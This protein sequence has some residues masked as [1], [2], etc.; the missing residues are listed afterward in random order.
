MLFMLNE[1]M[2]PREACDRWGITQ[3]ALRMKLKRAKKEGLVGRLIEEGKMKY[4]KPEEKQRGD[5][6]LTVE[7]MSV[8]FPKK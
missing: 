1:I 4:Y 6:I 3:D 8:L 2:T 5:W 7:A